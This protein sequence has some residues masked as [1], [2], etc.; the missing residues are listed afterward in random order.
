MDAF[1][2][3]APL[4]GVVLGSALTGIGAYAKQRGERKRTIAIALADLLEIRHR[5]IAVDVIVSEMRKYVELPPDII[6]TLREFSDSLLPDDGL[7]SRYNNAISLLAGVDP[8]LAFSLRSKNSISRVLG[9]LRN[10]TLE[11]GITPKTSETLE[12]ML[13]LAITPNLNDATIEL[14]SYHSCRTKHRIKRLIARAD[15]FP[16]EFAQLLDHLKSLPRD[17]ALTKSNGHNQTLQVRG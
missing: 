7:D 10:M 15:N 5:F 4:I 8:V 6:P 9:L 12:N 16:P 13:R 1:A 14:A 11:N 17:T 2:I 3:I